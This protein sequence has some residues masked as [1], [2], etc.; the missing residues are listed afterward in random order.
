MVDILASLFRPGLVLLAFWRGNSAFDGKGHTVC[1]RYTQ[2]GSIAT[3]LIVDTGVV[4]YLF[5][6]KTTPVARREEPETHFSRM[7]GLHQRAN[8][9]IVSQISS[10]EE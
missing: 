8:E 2:T 1:A 3:D 4:S 7:A 10:K 6:W 5:V 9:S